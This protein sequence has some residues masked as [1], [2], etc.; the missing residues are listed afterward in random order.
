[1]VQLERPPQKPVTALA[2]CLEDLGRRLMRRGLVILISDFLSPLDG[3]EL[4]LETL[5]QRGQEI[6]AFHLADPQEVR[7]DFTQPE[8][9]EDLETGQRVYV[10]PAWLRDNYQR[11][12][13]EHLANVKLCCTSHGV[14]YHLL[15]LD[16]PLETALPDVLRLRSSLGGRS[17][18]TK[19]GAS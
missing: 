2:R 7:F 3:L 18:R 17:R 10:D 11:Q 9:F 14:A 8:L 12:M 19:R 5:S 16:T 6:I 15:T 4:A 1:L 13:A